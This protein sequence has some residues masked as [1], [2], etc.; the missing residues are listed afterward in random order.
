MLYNP[1]ILLTILG[2]VVLVGCTT[3]SSESER[4]GRSGNLSSQTVSNWRLPPAAAISIKKLDQLRDQ[5]DGG[6]AA[7]RADLLSDSAEKQVGAAHAIE[8]LGGRPELEATLRQTLRQETD[9][10]T[11]VFVCRALAANQTA[12]EETLTAIREIR[13]HTDHPIVQT[14]AAGALVVLA[15]PGSS[16]NELQDLLDRLDPRQQPP[17]DEDG[18]QAFWESRWAAAYMIGRLG[19]EGKPLVTAIERSTEV[20]LMPNWVER[21]LF[22]TLR[23]LS[24]SN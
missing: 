12:T 6:T 13:R 7:L 5:A 1:L 11:R 20:L 23:D 4:S 14:Y 10:L 18:A 2:S 15:T 8:K 16:Q 19:A 9:P 3:T 24:R 22:L 21:Q 17:R